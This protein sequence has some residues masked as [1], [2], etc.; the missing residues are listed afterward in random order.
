M[1]NTLN[2]NTFAQ[3]IISG[4]NNLYNNKKTV[5]ELNVFP[6]PD[7]D[8]GTNMSLTTAAMAA[9][10]MKKSDMTL[11]K[12]ADTM[13]FAAL[14]GARGN[15]GVILSQFFRGISKSL[16]GKKE[17]NGAELALAL[18]DGS[19][20][21]YKAVMKPTEGTILTVAREV[22][23]GAQLAANTEDDIVT[24]M[25]KAVERGNKALKKTTQMLPALRQANV[26]DAGGQGWM[27]VLEGAL[28]YLKN[29]VVIEKAGADEQTAAP[30]VKSQETIKTEDIKFKY[31]T[32]F[33]VEKK[34]KGLSVDGFRNAIA[35]KGDCML[36]IDDEEIV[37][38]HI[39]T[40]HPGFVLE[41]AIKL[42]EMINLKIDNMKHQHKS[43]IEEAK[44]DAPVK[45]Q[46]AKK[47][48]P[49]PKQKKAPKAKEPVEIKDFGFV[50]VCMGKGITTILKD[51][52]V[53]K[54]IEGGQTMNPS[55]EDIL[56][57]V[58]RVKAKTI[59]VFPNN[60]N[61]IMAAQQAAELVED[62]KVVVIETKS[63]PQ[64][65]SAMMSFN[66]KR[67]ADTNTK[68][69]TKAIG[70]VSSAQITYA[71]RDTEID[72][73]TIKKDDILGM[74]EG[75]ITSVGK[76]IDDVLNNVISEMTDEDTEFITV[77]YGKEIKKP[78]ADRMLR[79][80]EA[81]YESDEIEVS[82]KK[83]G[84]PLYYYIVSVE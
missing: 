11:T 29:G 75:K 6:V 7:G 8:T 5:D 30:V 59:Y 42:G 23:I 44:N 74:V 36:V 56:K 20:A 21:A 72:G 40:N 24:V 31:C 47:A 10:L 48:E 37:K 19:D 76:D 27:F 84:Q 68:N 79:A 52:G 38:V 64:C 61:I 46:A 49:K 73:M 53:D 4:A 1:I 13:S 28:S 63:I 34:S 51:L 2:G 71:V 15:S 16:K 32:E 18:K 67:S 78:Q 80:L 82:F 57:A 39:H 35:P 50:A 66:A 41:E 43:I 69:M 12:A 33:I 65:I 55:T 58:K 14:R 25:E 54:I 17:C 70:K 3:M 22:A 45:V 81:K 83:G 26:V 77:Y 9:E 60:K 62:K